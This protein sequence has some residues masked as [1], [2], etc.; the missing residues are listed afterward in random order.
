MRFDFCIS[1]AGLEGQDL[2]G[3]LALWGKARPSGA[4]TFRSPPLCRLM[5][6]EVGV[7]GVRGCP[8]MLTM[9]HCH[10]SLRLPSLPQVNGPQPRHPRAS[11]RSRHP[12]TA[13]S[14]AHLPQ[15]YPFDRLLTT[16][17][18]PANLLPINSSTTPPTPVITA[19]LHL[20]IQALHR[21]LEAS[22][23]KRIL[24]V[25]AVPPK[26]QARIAVL[27]SG[28]L[29]CSTL[30]LMVDRLLPAGERIDLINVAFENPRVVEGKT[31]QAAAQAGGKRKKAMKGK[32]KGKGKGKARDESEME[33]DGVTEEQGDDVAMDDGEGEATTA[34]NTDAE[35]ETE[36]EGFS[37]EA[38]PT[39]LDGA[40]SIA[41]NEPPAWPDAAT[42]PSSP[43]GDGAATA[44]E[45]DPAVYEVPDRLTGRKSWEE[46]RRLRPT[47]VWNFVG[48][49]R[50]RQ[51]VESS[52]AD[53]AVTWRSLAEVNVPYQEM[54]EHRPKVIELMR[55][56]V[57]ISNMRER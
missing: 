48:E 8:R 30:A 41:G 14:L 53:F 23:R 46:L 21:E 24:N 10:R 38:S 27:F 52:G 28:G 7:S 9:L 17:P 12:A 54:L 50:P 11:S 18:L 6:D 45:V 4:L 57:L 29:D 42:Q 5:V 56:D 44:E 43:T 37:K 13:Q 25:P 20:T 55:C 26:P 31:R 19:Q 15:I 47:R 39:L 40:E 3:G 33:V 32:G 2:G 51:R 1:F 22:L 36:F 34:D 49:S 16:L 35:P